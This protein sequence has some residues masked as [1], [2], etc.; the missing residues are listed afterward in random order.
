[1]LIAGIAMLLT[2][3]PFLLTRQTANSKAANRIKAR[4][5]AAQ[6]P[7]LRPSS[8]VREA[9]KF[10]LDLKAIDVADAPQEVRHAMLSSR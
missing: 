6:A 4:Y 7:V 9:E 3:I 8:G 1:M 5:L 2:A 10:L